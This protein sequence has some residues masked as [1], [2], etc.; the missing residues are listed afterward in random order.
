VKYRVLLGKELTELWRSYR[1]IALAA[2]LVVM[3]ILSPVAARF[4]PDLVG[5]MGTSGFSIQMPPPTVADGNAQF[6][7]NL[8][9][10]GLVV[11][12]LIVMGSV[13]R[14]R[15]RGTAAMVLSKPASRAAFLAAKATALML[16]LTA[17]LLLSALLSYVYT[18]LLLGH[19]SAGAYLAMTALVG[20]YLTVV[21]AITFL[22]SAVF[23]SQLA[24]G[25]AAFLITIVLSL[26]LIIP[27]LANHVPDELRAW[28]LRAGSGQGPQAWGAVAVSLGVIVACMLGA[29]A[30]FRRAEL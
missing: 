6:V 30:V 28:A 23:R 16:A 29:W 5:M 25:G 19:V 9:Q 11:L 17:S 18:L 14:E 12:I 27:L 3:G 24:A 21:A 2:V 7:K 4:L 1:L 8:S 20:L 10:I 13:S 15:E 22:A 26:L